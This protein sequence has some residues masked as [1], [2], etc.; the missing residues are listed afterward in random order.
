M[1]AGLEI[2]VDVGQIIVHF[3]MVIVVT[4]ETPHACIGI[5]HILE[6]D[7]TVGVAEREVLVFSIE[8]AP[9]L[10]EADDIGGIDT[11]NL[12]VVDLLEVLAADAVSGTLLQGELTD[13]AQVGVGADAVVGDAQGNPDGSLATGSLA[14]DFHDPSFVGVA[15]GEGLAA[16]VV[17]I[18]LNEF[19]HAT[20]GFTGCGTT[21]QS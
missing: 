6:V 3:R 16:A 20:N 14:D 8:I 17:T 9:F 11:F 19:R 2:T 15:D 18:L 4:E 10:G 7:G 1:V 12:G 21:L 13:A 5:T